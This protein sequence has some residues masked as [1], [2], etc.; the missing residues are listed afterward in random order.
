MEK[1]VNRHH[2]YKNDFLEVYEDD[3]MLENGNPSKRIVVDHVGAACV[4]PL[5]KDG[6]VILVKQYR[7]SIGADA[8]EI[9]AGKK[10][11]VADETESTALRELQ[12]ETGYTADRLDYATTIYSAIGFSNEAIAIY[13]AKN[14][15]KSKETYTQDDDEAIESIIMPFNEA[16]NKVINGE[17]KD[18]KTVVALLYAKQ[19]VKLC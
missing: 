19:H 7:Y 5:T 8:L 12:E 13:I 18:A 2:I 1:K 10:D 17:I 14:V 4:L 16:Y 11:D 9:P 6:D 3:V 15:Y